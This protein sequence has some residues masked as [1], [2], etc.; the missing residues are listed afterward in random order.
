MTRSP[1]ECLLVIICRHHIIW[2]NPDIAPP[3]DLAIRPGQTQDPER[4]APLVFVHQ[5]TSNTLN[6]RWSRQSRDFKTQLVLTIDDDTLMED[7]VDVE[8]AFHV[9]QQHPWRLV[10]T[11]PRTHLRDSYGS[12]EYLVANDKD[13]DGFSSSFSS[14]SP[15][16]SPPKPKTRGLAGK[17]EAEN[18]LVVPI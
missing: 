13:K 4:Q 10:G 3:L 5:Q 11:Y 9:A 6:N 17:S 1:S 18:R 16:I 8:F 12:L 2:H 15:F 14:S 7:L